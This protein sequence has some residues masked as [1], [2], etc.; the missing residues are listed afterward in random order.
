V[1]LRLI[2]EVLAKVSVIMDLTPD[3]FANSIDDYSRDLRL[4][5]WGSRVSLHSTNPEPPTSALGQKQTSQCLCTMSA[6]PPIADIQ[7]DRAMAQW[8]VRR[9]RHALVPH[10]GKPCRR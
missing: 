10:W 1:C 5:K 3:L 4:A 7:F 8:Y 9:G 6:L 2:E